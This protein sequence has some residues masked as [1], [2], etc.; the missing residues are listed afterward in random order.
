MHRYITTAR[1][2]LSTSQ[3]GF[4]YKLPIA[5]NI[6]AIPQCLRPL[7][8]QLAGPQAVSSQQN[9]GRV[10]RRNLPLYLSVNVQHPLQ[11]NRITLIYVHPATGS[12][13]PSDS[14]DFRQSG[15]LPTGNTAQHRD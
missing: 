7:L 15:A 14:A 2:V 5:E 1:C 12:N 3:G 9:H 4:E 10:V 8:Q 11:G 6:D 13:S